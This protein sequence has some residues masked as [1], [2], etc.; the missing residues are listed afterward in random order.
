MAKVTVALFIIFNPLFVFS[1]VSGNLLKDSVTAPVSLKYKDPSLFKKFFLGK[2]YRTVWSTPVTFPVFR[3][4][5]KGFVME[6]L[7]GGQQTK[8]LRLKDKQGRGWVLRTVDK[9][10]EKALPAYLRNTLAQK[11]TQDM[12]SAAHPYAPLTIPTLAKAIGVIA[13]VPTFYFVPDDP[14]LEPHRAV[15]ANTICMLELREP[16]PDRS[17]TESTDKV[18]EELHEENDHLIIQK[19]VLRARLLDMLVGDWDRHADQWRWGKVDSGKVE[20]FYAIPRDR[21]QAYFNSNGLLVKIARI[22]ALRH[23]VGFH[24]DLDK[25]KSLNYKSW[26]FDAIFL[27]ELDKK[28]WESTIK[29]VQSALTDEVIHTAVRKL[30]RQIYPLSGVEIENKLKGR[31]NDLLQEGLDYYDYLAANALVN[32]TNEAEHFKISGSSD[33]LVV[34]VYDQKDGKEGRQIF[35]RTFKTADTK[36]I[37]LKGFGG[38]DHFTIEPNTNTR[39]RLN[40]Y[41]GEGSDHYDV[42]GNIKNTIYDVTSENNSIVNRSKSKIRADKQRGEVVK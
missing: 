29:S 13:P 8:S 14:A 34:K 23:L 19:A 42:K 2:N 16:T 6:E 3:I 37:T 40:L 33:S 10:V 35:Q 38:K 30:P 11:V 21:D 9:D 22:L 28:E 32:G 27:N 1:Q 18:L 36:Q 41:G 31:R 24:D 5:E 26:N 15:F 17:E 20:Y 12:V 7:G 39:I 25:L 4:K